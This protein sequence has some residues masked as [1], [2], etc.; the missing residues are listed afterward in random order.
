[1]GFEY[2]LNEITA[3]Y[4]HEVFKIPK[5]KVRIVNFDAGWCPSRNERRVE[6]QTKDCKNYIVAESN[7]IELRSS[8]PNKGYRNVS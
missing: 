6:V 3:Y 8:Q 7:I 2:T 5:Q 4:A 1:M